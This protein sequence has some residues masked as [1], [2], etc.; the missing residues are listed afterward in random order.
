MTH[1]QSRPGQ[2]TEAA[3]DRPG[4]KIGSESTT[5]GRPRLGRLG[6]D[7]WQADADQLDVGQALARIRD[8]RRYRLEGFDTFEDYCRERWG[9]SRVRAHQMIE[10]KEQRRIDAERRANRQFVTDV[11]AAFA[12]LSMLRHDQHFRRA[13]DNWNTGR[14]GWTVDELH[15]L[16]DI[17]HNRAEGLASA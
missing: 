11:Q 2:Q 4:G 5:G 16:A 13:V 12:A 7:D 10:A 8:G 9:F 14:K 17:L 1:I 3:D 15:E 6:A